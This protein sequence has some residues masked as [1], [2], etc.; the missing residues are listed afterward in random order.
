M[1]LSTYGAESK[2]NQSDAIPEYVPSTK[3]IS[4]YLYILSYLGKINVRI[5]LYGLY[6]PTLHEQCPQW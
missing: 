2:L 4:L 3:K 6:P 1:G 5:K